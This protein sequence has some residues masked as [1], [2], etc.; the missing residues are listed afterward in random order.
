[1]L[2]EVIT[3]GAFAGKAVSG[4]YAQAYSLL[5]SLAGIENRYVAVENDLNHAWN[6]VEIDGT[7]YH[8]DAAYGDFPVDG[9]ISYKYFMKNDAYMETAEPGR[10]QI[11][12]PADGESYRITSHNVCYTKLLRTV[13]RTSVDSSWAIKYISKNVEKLTGRSKLDFISQ[14][15]SWSDIVYP[16]DVV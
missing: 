15:I 9:Y 7:W 16:E 4:G 13:F 6:M 3:S 12:L 11:N 5:L 1:M 14:K 10:M 8:C 2:Y